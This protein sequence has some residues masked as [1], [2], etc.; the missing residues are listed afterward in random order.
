MIK[1]KR[2]R[3]AVFF[4]TIRMTQICI[5]SFLY[6]YFFLHKRKNQFNFI[7]KFRIKTE[8]EIKYFKMNFLNYLKLIINKII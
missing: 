6:S 4:A 2:N 3:Y 8:L 7:S 1:I 5:S